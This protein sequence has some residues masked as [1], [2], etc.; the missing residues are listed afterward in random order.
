MTIT[1]QGTDFED[2]P[3]SLRVQVLRRTNDHYTWQ[4]DEEIPTGWKQLAKLEY[5]RTN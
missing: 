5:L 1:F 3:A 4:L 2:K